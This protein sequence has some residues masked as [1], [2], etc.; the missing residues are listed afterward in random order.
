MTALAQT[1]ELSGG[2]RAAYEVVGEGEPLFFFQGGPG[3][4]ANLLRPEAELLADRFAVHLVDPHGSGGSTP[5]ADPSQYDHL[6]TARFYDE[7]QRALGIERA[8]IMGI[9][10]GGV[11]ALT[12]AARFPEATAR[13]VAIAAL[14]ISP[15]GEGGADAAAEMDRFLA[16]HAD[17]PWYPAA[18]KTWDEWTERVLAAEDPGEVDAMMAEVLPLYFADP[19]RP[20]AQR[21]I[22]TW[23]RDARG[24]LAA[25]KVWEGGL[26]Q[27]IDL[28]PLLPEVRAPLLVLVGG[29]D[30]ICGPAQGELIAAAVPQSELVIVP[31][32][33]HFVPAEAPDEFRRAVLDFAAA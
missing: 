10:F 5:P 23:R 32:C 29:L 33:G 16:R 6:G 26:W 28:R 25:S 15:E 20:G 2:R 13:C 27:T 1:V 3:F 9:S 18:R 8:T 24:D 22:E 17:Q 21:M 12:Y 30:P 14:A 7:V 19:E 4:S 31:D 11:V